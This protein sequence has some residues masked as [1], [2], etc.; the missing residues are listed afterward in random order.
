MFGGGGLGGALFLSV[1]FLGAFLWPL[2]LSCSPA[3]CALLQGQS[4]N[5]LATCP[6]SCLEVVTIAW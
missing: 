4:V 3:L 1:F 2:L 5:S 6:R